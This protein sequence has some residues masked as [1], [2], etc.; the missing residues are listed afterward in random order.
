MLSSGGMNVEYTCLTCQQ[1]F[2]SEKGLCPHLQQFFTSAEGQKIWRIRLLHRYAY[3]FYSDS[4][5]QE[6]VRE[7]PLMVSEVLCVEQ[8]DTR[9]YTGLNALGQRVSILE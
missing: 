4:Q 7:Q 3:E 2:A 6:L 9:T 5:M 8:F 1:V